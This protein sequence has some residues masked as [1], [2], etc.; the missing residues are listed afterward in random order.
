VDA[1]HNLSL[2]L[3]RVHNC[4]IVT[5]P[6]QFSAEKNR[7]AVWPVVKD[8]V[9]QHWLPGFDEALAFLHLVLWYAGWE[10]QSEG[11]MCVRAH[12]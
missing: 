11:S 7:E 6:R 8:E 5:Q 12:A 4:V 1:P 2:E 10:L 3:P 9:L